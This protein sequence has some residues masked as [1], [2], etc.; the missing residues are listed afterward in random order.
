MANT[1]CLRDRQAEHAPDDRCV[2]RHPVYQYDGHTLMARYYEDY[3]CNG[4]RLAGEELDT[5]GTAALAA[6][7]AL[8]EAPENWVEFR[9]EQG[10]LQYINNRQF[11]H[12]RTAFGDASGVRSPRHML[13]LWNRDEGTAGL[14]G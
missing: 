13:R 4:F 1:I 12:A 11:A 6:M 2:S 10:Q 9:I 5:V 14:E 3:V 8:L 7:R